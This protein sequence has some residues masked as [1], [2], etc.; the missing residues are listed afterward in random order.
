MEVETASAVVFRIA[1]T[2]AE[3]LV[4]N[5]AEISLPEET[6]LMGSCQEI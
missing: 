1:L 6:I 4:K 5:G 2:A 3:L